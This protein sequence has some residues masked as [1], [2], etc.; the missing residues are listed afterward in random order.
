MK[1]VPTSVRNIIQ[2]YLNIV[3]WRHIQMG[4]PQGDTKDWST[5][6]SFIQWQEQQTTKAIPPPE[7]GELI[8]SLIYEPTSPILVEGLEEVKGLLKA[9]RRELR[10]R[11]YRK[12]SRKN[13]GRR[14]SSNRDIRLRPQGF[15]RFGTN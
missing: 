15:N 8:R 3:D 9:L 14:N 11:G 12:L 13:Y 1:R 10:C 7:A 2:D 5:S 4:G 6:P